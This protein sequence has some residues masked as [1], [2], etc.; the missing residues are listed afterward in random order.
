[1]TAT[2]RGQLRK[3]E[4]VH[5]EDV[6]ATF[7][8]NIT[9]TDVDWQGFVDFAGIQVEIEFKHE[10]AKFEDGQE[11]AFIERRRRMLD[12]DWWLLVRHRGESGHIHPSFDITSFAGWQRGDTEPRMHGE[13]WG[14][15]VAFLAAID[16][17]RVITGGAD[18]GAAVDVG[19]TPSAAPPATIPDTG[20]IAA[21]IPAS[22]VA[23]MRLAARIHSTPFV[24]KPLR[25]DPHSVLACILT[26]E[27]L[28]LG[29]M[30]SLRMVNVIEGRPAAS[31]ELMRALVNRAGH[32]L[33]VVDATVQQVTLYGQ[34]RDTGAEARV[35]WTMQ[36]AQRAKLT[37]NPAWGKYPRSMLL[38][39]ATSEL[40]RMLFADVIGGLYT[41]EETAAIEG[42][43]YE[44]GVHELVDPVTDVPVG[45]DPETGEI[46]A[47]YDQGEA[48][49]AE[50]EADALWVDEARDE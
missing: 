43:V 15:L 7:P 6:R 35:T 25:G 45:V 42:H 13:G 11:R 30:Q 33:S 36:D 4:I 12:R 3:L 10:H 39:R 27:E 1:V 28:G 50:D 29:P 24:P 49:D 19:G 32:R 22:W 47:P 17:R 20:S 5:W 23:A 31:A 18:N 21:D 38:A 2:M 46:D 16:G 26:G 48:L 14:E 34:R 9:P 37:T 41:P 40:C 44:P 8:R